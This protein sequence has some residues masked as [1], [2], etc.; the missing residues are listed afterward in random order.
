V[1]KRSDSQIL[2]DKYIKDIESWG[3]LTL[4]TKMKDVYMRKLD[5]ERD[6]IL[7]FQTQNYNDSPLE[8]LDK[9]RDAFERKYQEEFT[10]IYNQIKE[11][12]SE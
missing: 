10:K 5:R 2:A 1:K 7:G 3:I 8:N 11:K 4:M 6:I 12:L 9:V